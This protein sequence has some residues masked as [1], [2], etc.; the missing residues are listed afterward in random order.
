MKEFDNLDDIRAEIDRID[1]ELLALISARAE[2]SLQVAKIKQ[3]DAQESAAA[4]DAIEYYRPEREAQIL[5]R[6]AERNPG[7][8][9][10]ASAQRF[11][12]EI[13][14]TSLALEQP[15]KIAYLGPE[16]TYTQEACYK[17]F[18]HAVSTHACAVIDDVFRSVARGECRFGIVPVENSVEGSVVRTLDSLIDSPL[19]I[20]GEVR[21]RIRHNLLTHAADLGAI[22]RVQAHPQALAQCRHWLEEHLPGVV[23]EE[24]SSNAAAVQ[25][26]RD[27]H[28]VAAIAG[29]GAADLYSIPVLRADIEDAATNTTRFVI[30]GDRDVPPSGNDSTS[31][32]VSAP[33]RPGGLRRMLEP[34]EEAGISMTR[35]ESRPSGSALWAYVFFID[36]AGHQQDEAMRTALSGLADECEFLRVLGSYPSA[37]D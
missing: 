36:V 28:D 14:S 25:L 8:L 31:L 29:K 4:P 18:G 33:H 23:R 12:R 32:L 5:R 19:R 2:C 37:L 20:C 17:H 7:P 1:Q 34:F 16:G 26:A 11:F 9:D 27:K 3:R 6:V 22:R 21:L 13:I 35:I 30:L 10:D 15:M 24:A